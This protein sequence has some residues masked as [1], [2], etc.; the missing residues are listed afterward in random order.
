MQNEIVEIFGKNRIK[1]CCLSMPLKGWKVVKYNTQTQVVDKVRSLHLKQYRS[2]SQMKRW[3]ENS[4]LCTTHYHLLHSSQFLHLLLHYFETLSPTSAYLFIQ[5]SG[6][7]LVL[8]WFQN[9]A[10]KDNLGILGCY[11]KISMWKHMCASNEVLIGLSNT[12][13]NVFPSRLSYVRIVGKCVTFQNRKSDNHA[14]LVRCVEV[15]KQARFK[16]FI[17]TSTSMSFCMYSINECD[18][19]MPLRKEWM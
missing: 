16:L 13:W 9:A 11:N 7:C 12:V 6:W 10:L 8:S 17:H 5:H 15:W 3:E 14:H 2:L 4:Y 18:T 1:I 19:W